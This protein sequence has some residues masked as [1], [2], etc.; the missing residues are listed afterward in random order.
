MEGEAAAVD[1][2]IDRAAELGHTM[3]VL[4]GGEPTIRP[5]LLRWARRSARRGLDFGLVTNGRMLSY[6]AL[7]EKLLRLRLRYVYLSLHGGTAKVHNAVVRS[8]AFDQTAGAL[9]NLSGTGIDLS[10]NCVVT[11][12]NLQHLREVVDLCAEFP[13]VK[14]KFSMTEP[15]GG[16]EKLFDW[17]VAPVSEVAEAVSDAIHYGWEKTGDRLADGTPRYGHGGIPLCLMPGLEHLYDDLRTHGFASM[18]ETW[19][20]DF[21]PVDDLNKVHPEPCWDCGLRGA[22]PG[23]FTGYAAR[24]GSAELRPRRAPRS[25]SFN[26]VP[27]WE[28]T[29]Q[30]GTPCPIERSG[31]TPYDRGRTL[32]LRRGE[33]IVLHRTSTRDFADAELLAVKHR[34]GQVYLDRSRKTAPDDFAR[35][36][37]KLVRVAEC[38]DCAQKDACAGTW[39]VL[40]EDVFSRDDALLRRKLEAISGSVLDVG[41]GDGRYAA[42]LMP[43]AESGRIRYLGIDPDEAALA[44]L[45]ARWPSA[46]LMA[47][48]A[49]AFEPKADTFDHVLI[50]QSWNHLSDPRA[51]AERLVRALRP[52]GTLLVADNVAFGLIRSGEQARRAEESAARFEHYRNHSSEDAR[53]YFEGLPLTLLEERPVGPKTSNQWVLHFERSAEA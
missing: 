16:G 39:R 38:E 10:V 7:T 51:V 45:R 3:A 24:W 43:L 42:V 23:L 2:K 5:E 17:I 27:V 21:H 26:L 12:T 35:D 1:R 50:L 37:R 19:E 9:P 11:K 13:D 8:D 30:P 14:L 34:L 52:G 6:R 36:L 40:D 46:R 44:R 32:F 22:C 41:C 31:I 4:S 29:W 48:E 47:I 49:E 15:K 53:A 33:R 25:N 18:T 20:D 28:R